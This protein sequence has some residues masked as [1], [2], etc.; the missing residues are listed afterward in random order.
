MV[1]LVLGVADGVLA[2]RARTL[3][4]TEAALRTQTAQQVVVLSEYFDRSET[5][6]LLLARDPS[7]EQLYSGPGGRLVVGQNQGQAQTQVQT[8]ALAQITDLL[9]Y[10][11]RLYP[12]RISEACLIDRGGAELARVVG[13]QTALF[14]LLSPDESQNAFFAPTLK[15]RPGRVL[16]ARPYLSPDTAQWVI[17]NSALISR[18]GGDAFAILHFEVTLESFRPAFSGSADLS[19]VD[20]DTGRVLVD[21]DRPVAAR[22]TVGRSDPAATRAAGTKADRGSFQ[23][24]GHQVAFSR[25]PSSADNQ[26]HWLVMARSRAADPSWW[27]TLGVGPFVL[28]LG[29][30]LLLLLALLARRSRLRQAREA[31]LHDPLTGLPNRVLLVDRTHQAVALAVRQRSVAALLLLDLDRFK[32]VND[33]LGHQFGDQLLIQVSQRLRGLLRASDTVARLGGDEFALLLPQISGQQAALAVADKVIAALHESFT[34]E[35]TVLDIEASIGLAIAPEHGSDA[36]TLLRHADVAMY[37]AKAEHAAVCVYKPEQDGN[38]LDR[39]ALLGDLRRALDGGELVVHY[40]PKVELCT[41]TLHGV[42]ALVRWQHPTRG[43]LPPDDFIPLAENTGLI[44]RLT[45]Y[46]LEVSIRQAVRW[47]DAG[48]PVQIAVNLSARC[49]ADPQLP[50]DVARALADAGLDSRWLRLEITESSIMAD[51]AAAL[52]NLHQLHDQGIGLS[53]DDFG[54][55]YSSMAYLKLLPLDELKVDRSFIADLPSNP[56]DTILIRSA[57]D[58]GHNL[59]MKVVAEGVEDGSTL[60]TLRDLGCDVVQ[61][62]YLGRPMARD[63]LDDWL[64]ARESVGAIPSLGWAGNGRLRAFDERRR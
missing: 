31:A 32:E 57:V 39:L 15:L 60:Q 44:H 3:A 13:G 22:G 34:I 16:Q 8:Q 27:Q 7:F 63:Q 52:H 10:L 30:G 56:D 38:T 5:V 17:S 55:G 35:G 40:Q 23:A 49:L 12:G 14:G 25:V 47:R 11:Q 28:L 33:T 37:Q 48:R 20:A 1:M 2:S 36:D 42:E 62:Y 54:T 53:I 24:G 50:S 4:H 6:N 26:N 18:P 61:G 43:F 29:A 9:R 21:S 58:L 41:D 45:L 51:P 64:A 19:I 46:V 59:G